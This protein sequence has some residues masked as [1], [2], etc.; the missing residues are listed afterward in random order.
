MYVSLV[1][2]ATVNFDLTILYTDVVEENLKKNKLDLF[3]DQQLNSQV[4]VQKKSFFRQ[5]NISRERHLRQN[6]PKR[7]ADNDAREN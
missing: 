1:D 3:I 5:N 4:R 2:Y 6:L 7:R